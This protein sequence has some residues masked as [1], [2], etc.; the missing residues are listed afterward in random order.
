MLLLTFF[1]G[2]AVPLSAVALPLAELSLPLPEP[3]KERGGV[4]PPELEEER[5]KQSL[6]S[7]MRK[8]SLA[9]T[10][11]SDA[12]EAIKVYQTSTDEVELMTERTVKTSQATLKVGLSLLRLFLDVSPTQD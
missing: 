3:W 6:A 10:T 7:Q 1:L 2:A 4:T 8:Q 11:I 5:I 12:K 9:G